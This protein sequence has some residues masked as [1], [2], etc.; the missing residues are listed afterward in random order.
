[1]AGIQNNPEF[2][3][4]FFPNFF[5]GPRIAFI[6]FIKSLFRFGRDQRIEKRIEKLKMEHLNKNWNEMT[7]EER[8]HYTYARAAV[9]RAIER[10]LR[11]RY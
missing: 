5:P 7:E 11:L 4:Y 3:L 1:M 2:P 8:V 6:S 10:M 9:T